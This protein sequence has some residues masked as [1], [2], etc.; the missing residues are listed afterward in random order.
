MSVLRASVIQR[1]QWLG[2]LALLT[3]PQLGIL[4]GQQGS[5]RPRRAGPHQILV[6]LAFLP[7]GFS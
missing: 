5:L 3:L 6:P 7:W 1:A 2:L 4:A